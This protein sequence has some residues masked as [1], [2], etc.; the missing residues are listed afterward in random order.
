MRHSLLLLPFLFPRVSAD[1]PT[2]YEYWQ[3]DCQGG[4][5]ETFH[6][7]TA[8]NCSDTSAWGTACLTVD[9]VALT[10]FDATA[11]QKTAG[12]V[13]R[14]S[15]CVPSGRRNGR[16][17]WIY[18]TAAGCDDFGATCDT[19][20]RA[21]SVKVWDACDSDKDYY[22]DPIPTDNECYAL[23]EKGASVRLSCINN[24]YVQAVVYSDTRCA[25][26]DGS[27]QFLEQA[28]STCYPVVGS[29]GSFALSV[30]EGCSCDGGDGDPQLIGDDKSLLHYDITYNVTIDGSK[31]LDGTALD[32]LCEQLKQQTGVDHVDM[33]IGS[34]TL[35]STTGWT[36]NVGIRFQDIPESNVFTFQ[37]DVNEALSDGRVLQM[38][39]ST[40]GGSNVTLVSHGSNIL[41]HEREVPDSSGPPGFLQR[42]VVMPTIMACFLLLL[43]Q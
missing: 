11:C 37:E 12:S 39:K 15:E 30:A 2:C 23:P 41:D 18:C 35:D 4:V 28:G 1:S 14:T 29:A 5:K 32:D 43:L 24:L 34:A 27:P 10:A 40:C 22:T 25:T 31:C 9:L 19:V 3:A 13:Q 42:G 7:L 38:V 33:V 16:P 21:G 8:N 20:H 26:Q 6:A 17:V 36:L